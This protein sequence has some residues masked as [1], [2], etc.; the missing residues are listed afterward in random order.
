V[1]VAKGLKYEETWAG[2]HILHGG[3]VEDDMILKLTTL[4]CY[5][6]KDSVAA[7]DFDELV[8]LLGVGMQ[9]V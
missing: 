6:V 1:E 7:L 3:E 9:L 2:L 4:L 8:T 5:S